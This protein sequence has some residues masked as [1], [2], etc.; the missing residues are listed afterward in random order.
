M[1]LTLQRARP[2]LSE[3]LK[4]ID[5]AGFH[6]QLLGLFTDLVDE[7]AADPAQIRQRYT[8]LVLEAAA[9]AED[10]DDARAF[11]QHFTNKGSP[12]TSSR[13]GLAALLLESWLLQRG[14]KLFGQFVETVL[15][16]NSRTFV[17]TFLG[18][19]TVEEEE[20]MQTETAAFVGRW[21]SLVRACDKDY[22]GGRI[23][24]VTVFECV[25]GENKARKPGSVPSTAPLQT[26]PPQLVGP[27]PMPAGYEGLLPRTRTEYQRVIDE[28][29]LSS[30]AMH[31][32]FGRDP[33][34][35]MRADEGTFLVDD[36]NGVAWVSADRGETWQ[37]RLEA[38]S[39]PIAP[40][41]TR[42]APVRRAAVRP[43]VEGLSVGDR[44]KVVGQVA[45]KGSTGVVV[46]VAPSGKFY[47]VDSKDGEFLGYYHESDLKKLR[48]SAAR[49]SDFGSWAVCESPVAGGV[50]STVVGVNGAAWVVPHPVEEV[51]RAVDRVLA[52][53][54][55][56]AEEG[57]LMAEAFLREYAADCGQPVSNAADLA[58]WAA[59]SEDAVSRRDATIQAHCTALVEAGAAPPPPKEKAKGPPGKNG[60]QPPPPKPP[61][62]PG[63]DD[64]DADEPVT[65]DRKERPPFYRDD[66]QRYFDLQKSLDKEDDEALSAVKRK[67]K[68]TAKHELEVTPAGEV[69]ANGIVDDP[70][71]PKPASATAPPPGGVPAP[72]SPLPPEGEEEQPPPPKEGPAQTQA[73][74]TRTSVQ[75]STKGGVTT[76]KATKT[77][78]SES[79]VP[80]RTLDAAFMFFVTHVDDAY[81]DDFPAWVREHAPHLAPGLDAWQPVETTLQE[82]RDDIDLTRALLQGGTGTYAPESGLRARRASERR[83]R[84]IS[85][86][87]REQHARWERLANAKLAAVMTF[88]TSEAFSRAFT[89]EEDR[90]LARQSAAM[91]VRMK[92]TPVEEWTDEMWNWCGRQMRFISRLRSSK[93]GL[94]EHGRL[95]HKYLSLR[96][97]G[98]DPLVRDHLPISE[99]EQ[100]TDL[101]DLHRRIDALSGAAPHPLEEGA[102]AFS[103]LKKH[104]IE[105]SADER[106]AVLKA[107]AVWHPTHSKSPHSAVW[108]ATVGEQT[109]YVV[110]T[111]RAYKTASSLSDA[112]KHYPAIKKTA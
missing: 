91:L 28:G 87:K 106:A 86:S 53:Y 25:A 19:V 99:V 31:L 59:L 39:L 6:A 92:S 72:P 70:D 35:S 94:I 74:Q 8:R 58:R 36:P 84:T 15:D 55:G 54:D 32:V 29:G 16:A 23:S 26:S 110:N 111:H 40:A 50:S 104:K 14:G 89:R 68:L 27:P 2:K 64:V 93:G 13:N 73:Q 44:V 33:F 80:V 30:V 49:R 47:G 4:G 57:D 56:L 108:K 65:T 63:A 81:L 60:E 7:I 5:R 67:F 43:V 1:A 105:L 9:S 79:V 75:A 3:S 107:G 102:P 85:D 34:Q 109:W 21:T 101:A 66:L 12:Y 69:R 48:E 76:V 88:A 98:H 78:T 10:E 11:A 96:A 77:S 38:A 112:I 83:A 18:E 37:P 41:P 103:V 22:E 45:G 95:T 24:E 100:A 51:E 46:Q 71:A 90:Q 20:R 62:R 97:W 52:L 17:A 61:P 82:A 42:A